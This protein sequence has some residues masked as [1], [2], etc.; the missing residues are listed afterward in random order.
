MIPKLTRTDFV[1]RPAAL[2]TYCNRKDQKRSK[3]YI[4]RDFTLTNAIVYIY[5]NGRD[6]TPRRN[7]VKE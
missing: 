3:V 2:T 4:I 6:P 1:Q 7:L 5:I